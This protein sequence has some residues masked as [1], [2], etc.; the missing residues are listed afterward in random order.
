MTIDKICLSYYNNPRKVVIADM[1]FFRMPIGV[2]SSPKDVPGGSVNDATSLIQ[3][4][5]QVI[6]DIYD[7]LVEL[8]PNN[9]TKQVMGEVFGKKINRYTFSN[10]AIE[11][12]SPSSDLAYKPFKICIITSIHG[13]EQGAAWTTALFFKYLYSSDNP[14][15]A[16]LRRHVVF[17]VIPVA[18]PS[19]FSK[20]KRND[21]GVDLNRNYEPDFIYSDDPKSWGYGGPQPASELETQLIMRFIEENLDAKLVLDYHNIDKGYPLFY[22]YGQKDVQL[23]Q[24]VFASLSDKW[25]YEYPEFP[26]DQLLGYVRSN[27]KKGMLCDYVASKGLWVL[28]METPWCMPEIGKEQ[29][30]APTIRCALDLL[31]NT[32]IAVV[33][34]LR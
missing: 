6:Y 24:S 31:V 18:N 8:Y 16:M 3:S 1:F 23:A 28:T 19:G 2:Y 32:L 22:V 5:E 29:Y 27:G 34:N 26:K 4:T 33:E 30:D 9:V 7:D 14:Y 21:N 13:Y 12:K 25:Q 11:N 17:D 15:M 10:F 20:N